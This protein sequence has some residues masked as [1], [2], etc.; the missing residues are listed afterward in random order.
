MSQ[1]VEN[2]SIEKWKDRTI[3]EIVNWIRT[4]LSSCHTTNRLVICRWKGLSEYGGGGESYVLNFLSSHG[5]EKPEIRREAS[6][7]ANQTQPDVFFQSHLLRM[8]TW[9][10]VLERR[11]YLRM[12]QHRATSVTWAISSDGCQW[13]WFPTSCL[14]RRVFAGDNYT[15]SWL[16][17]VLR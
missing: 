1:L 8:K 16:Y 10:D 17:N 7:Y 5:L 6:A 15:T 2:G 11:M 12:V 14:S 3:R 9:R 4:I 13:W